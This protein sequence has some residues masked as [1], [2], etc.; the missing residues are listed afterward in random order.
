MFEFQVSIDL[1]VDFSIASIIFLNLY[2]FYFLYFSCSLS[3]IN[4]HK[5]DGKCEESYLALTT[6]TPEAITEDRRPTRT[7][8]FTTIDTVSPEILERLQH[9]QEVLDILQNKH[10]RNFLQEIDK[11]SNSW[12]A[13]K[14]AMSEPIFLEFANECLKVTENRNHLEE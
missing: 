1:L 9:S 3:C 12:N 6:K 14:L 8:V 10:L 5:T 13:M 11:A 7:N 4:T 2:R